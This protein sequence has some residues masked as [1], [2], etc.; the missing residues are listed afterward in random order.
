MFLLSVHR[1]SLIQGPF[2][3]AL[4]FAKLVRPRSAEGRLPQKHFGCWGQRT[5]GSSAN[6]WQHRV[7]LQFTCLLIS[8]KTVGTA[9]HALSAVPIAA[10]ATPSLKKSLYVEPPL[11]S[12][13]PSRL[14]RRSW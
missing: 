11:S 6:F 7:S 5:A 8:V 13:R 12:M 3:A 2:C 10:Y 1:A 14:R 4:I 9:A